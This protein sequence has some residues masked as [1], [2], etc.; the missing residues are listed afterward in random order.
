MTTDDTPTTTAPRAARWYDEP[1]RIFQMARTS[2][3]C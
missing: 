2:S 3:T 1:S